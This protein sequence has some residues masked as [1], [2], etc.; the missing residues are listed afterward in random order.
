[1]AA[2]PWKVYDKAKEHIGDGI[3]DLDDDSFKVALATSASN[4]AT[5][6]LETFASVTNEVAAGNGYTAG[7]NPLTSPTWVEASGTVTFDAVDPS[8]TASGGSI[9]ARFAYIYDDTT[10]A[11]ADALICYSLLDNTPA[12]VTVTDTNTLTLQLSASGI[13]DVSGGS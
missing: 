5:I 4:A 3:I 7:G 8:W 11:P 9:V 6:T 10:T 13:F 12:D 2:D 1:M